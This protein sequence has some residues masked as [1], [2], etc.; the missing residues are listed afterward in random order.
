MNQ[1][2]FKLHYL[3]N[4]TSARIPNGAVEKRNI[5]F[6]CAVLFFT[7]G[8]TANTSFAI[9]RDQAE[10]IPHV[11]QKAKDSFIQY[12]YASNHKAYAIAP[13]GAWAWSDL[14]A[15]ETEAQ[16]IAKQQCQLHTQQTCV[17]YASNDKIVFNK[18]DWTQLWRLQKNKT[19]STTSKGPSRA[20]RFPNLKFKDKKGITHHLSDFKNKITLVHFWGSWCPPC[21]REMPALM[22]LQ[23][24]LKQ[25]YGNKVKMILLQVREPFSQS[26]TWAKEQNFD[27]LPLYNSGVSGDEDEKLHTANGQTLHDRQLA[28]VFPSSYVLDRQGRVLFSHRG[29]IDNWLEYL[30]FFTDIV[31]QTKK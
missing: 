3:Q 4:L 19:S 29:P 18:Q 9:E 27:K 12:I 20:S 13:G 26:L 28:K 1:R 6:F 30:P 8:L 22:R 17:V 10:L 5:V 11:N 16:K 24:K 15:T 21:M 2:N 7:L 31:T 14:A 23:Q 25:N